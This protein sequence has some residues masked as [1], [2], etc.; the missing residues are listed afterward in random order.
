VSLAT[1]V[2][3]DADAF[4]VS[5]E[6]ALRPELRGKKVA[7]GGRT[8]GIISSASYEARSSGV[9]T[10]MPTQRALRVCPDLILLPHEGDYSGVSRRMF[11]LCEDLTPLVQRNSIDEGYLDLGPCGLKT[12]AEVEQVVRALQERIWTELEVPVSMGIATNRL[13]AQVASKLRK[14]RGFVIVP[15]GEEAAFMAPLDIKEMPGVGKRSQERLREQ[16]I[17]TMGDV[18]AQTDSALAAVVGSSW[19]KFRQRCLGQDDRPVVTERDEAKSWSHQRT[20]ATDIGDR[21]RIEAIAKGLIDDLMAKIRKEGR[22]VRTLTVLVRYPD[23][24][25][26]SSGRSLP[27][28]TDLE[29]AFYPLV[30][31]LLEK[32]WRLSRPL[33]LV[34]VK[35]SG[36]DDGPVQMDIFGGTDSKRRRLAGVMDQLNAQGEGLNLVRAHQLKEGD[37]I[38]RQKAREQRNQ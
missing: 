34:S 22:R 19:R 11:D 2:H 7:V 15:P 26:E 9:Y 37:A 24:Q 1:I 14:P 6:L 10:P 20:F 28:A 8:R 12:A 38:R 17:H 18:V 25:Q 31:P 33:R 3:L 35:L 4:F 16:D 21:A 23:F 36:V 29:T 30:A 32:A 5:V 13:V 27:E